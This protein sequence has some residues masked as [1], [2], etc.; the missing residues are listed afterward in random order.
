MSGCWYL[1]EDVWGGHL[2]IFHLSLS[3]GYS[4]TS[5]EH[6]LLKEWGF[7]KDWIG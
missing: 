3:P 2:V 1:H 4:G 5:K 6:V 7:T